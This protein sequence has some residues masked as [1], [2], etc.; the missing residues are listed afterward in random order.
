MPDLP[1]KRI[2]CLVPSLTELLVDLGLKDQLIGRT[3]FCIH[4]EGIEDVEIIG[5]TKN[6]NLEK[7]VE[8]EP[9]FI[10]ANKEENRKEDI[11]LL[12]KYA[13]VRVTEIDSIQDAILEISSLGDI[14]GVNKQAGAMVNKITALLNDRPAKSPLS[15]AYFIWKDPWMTVGSDTYIHDVLH[16]YGLDNVYGLHKRYPKTYLDEL[17]AHSPELILLSSEPYP[18]KEK[19]I[20]EIKEVC[21]DFRVVLINGEWFSWYGSRMIKAFSFLN[22]WRASL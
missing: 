17:S 10:L 12:E 6:P 5:G 3:R 15:V 20:D 1:Y 13:K 7:I 4:P 22:E 2:V 8:L 19:H 21:P 11:E 18:F 16:K 9:D 14:L